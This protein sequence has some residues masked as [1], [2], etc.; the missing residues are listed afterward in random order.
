MVR[1]RANARVGLWITAT[2]WVVGSCAKGIAPPAPTE[3]ADISEGLTFSFGQADACYS[4][5]QKL[6]G[7]VGSCSVD[8]D[9]VPLTF[10][11]VDV[12]LSPFSIDV[13]EV[14]NIQYEYCV[15]MDACTDPPYWNAVS[16]EQQDYYLIDQW[17]DHPVVNVTW[18]QA[19]AY[20]AFVHKRLPTEVEWERVAKGNR[21]A[22]IERAYPAEGFETL[23]D[24]TFD[25]PAFYCR[26][27]A[28]LDPVDVAPADFVVE[29]ET[30]IHHLFG[31]AA[32]WVDAW[33]T[34]GVTCKEP[35]PEGCTRC[36]TCNG[37]EGDAWLQCQNDCKICDACAEDTPCHYGCPDDPQRAYPVCL[38]YGASQ[39]PIDPSLLSAN[40]GS[41]KAVRGGS[42]QYGNSSTCRF[43]SDHR[44]YSWDQDK[45]QNF[46]GFRC[47]R[48]LV[49]G[50]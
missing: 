29:G 48:D 49:P 37:K 47:A 25:M 30:R 3:M 50:T 32:E 2:L 13:H 27:E 33:Y 20:C 6:L 14:S 36:D 1:G 12:A 41:G 5:S 26:Q 4:E 9:H 43:R 7:D 22:G 46:L 38:A 11:L 23:A 31:N 24:C 45:S 10:P 34:Q 40:I 18:K 28:T 35:L 19:A 42:A 39:Q 21:D 8:G 16:P 15:A 17:D 44:D